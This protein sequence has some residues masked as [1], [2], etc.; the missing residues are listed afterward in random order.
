MKI[1]FILSLILAIGCNSQG[2][3]PS[4]SSSPDFSKLTTN[5]YTPVAGNPILAKGD[6]FTNATWN[7]PHVLKS[8]G[9]YIMY[10]S[11][12][13]NF[14]QNIKIYRLVSSN[15]EDWSLSP[16][17][18]VLSK[19]PGGADWDR[20]S[21]ETPA[22]VK[23]NGTYYMFYTGYPITQTDSTSYQI[24]YATS[25]DGINWTKHG[26][27]LAPTDPSGAPNLDFNQFVVAEPAPVVFQNKIYL[28]FTA[29]GANVGVGTTLQTIGLT[30]FDGTS[31]SAPQK[32][33]EPDQAQYPRG[34]N[35]KGYSTP[36]AIV[37]N[38]KV[39]LYF[40]VVTETPFEQVKIHHASSSDGITSWTQDSANIF[41]R[42]EFSP[43]ADVDL[44]AP[45]ALL[46]GKILRLYFAGNGDT[47]AFPNVQMGI[48]LAK[49]TL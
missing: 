47:S 48:G 20:K 26:S 19:G 18:A 30:T 15:G 8:G 7:D 45:A 14:D 29:L 49:C 17:S 32:V 43:W 11:A 35:W 31:W 44:R 28:Y 2:K 4:G 33:L 16:S 24:G 23:F 5:C 21:V 1:F 39:H 42:S 3:N 13:A 41:D 34:S 40:D 10:A 12:D 37:M 25:A 38:N 27:L 6:L 22:V 46:D 9:Q 36:N